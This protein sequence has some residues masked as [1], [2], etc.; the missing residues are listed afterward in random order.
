[1]TGPSIGGPAVLLDA[2]AEECEGVSRIVL[3][4]DEDAF[5]LPTRCPA[6]NVK[7]LLAHLYRDVDRLRTGLQ[8]PPPDAVDTTAVSYWRSYDRETTPMAIADRAKELSVSYP[9]GGELALAWDELWRR[10]LEEARGVDGQRPV[11]TWGPVLT[12]E[13]FLKTRV[14]EVAVHGADLTD[15]LSRSPD[16][17][18]QGL[19]TSR[20]ILVGL[21]GQE[22]PADLEWDDLTFM[23]KGTGRRE[24]TEQEAF[25]LGDLAEAFPLLG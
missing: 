12:L 15:A 6:W 21:L 19:A 9:S 22:P 16:L 13:E 11:A 2:L 7:E 1:M 24:L 23:E 18:P 5:G 4:L 3:A 25:L 8:E 17:T 14:L 20:E 10:A